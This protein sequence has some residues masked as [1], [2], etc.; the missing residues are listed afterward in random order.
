MVRLAPH[1][2]AVPRVESISFAARRPLALRHCG[3]R[4]LRHGTLLQCLLPESAALRRGPPL[5]PPLQ[6]KSISPASNASPPL[7]EQLLHSKSKPRSFVF[8]Y[9]RQHSF[10]SLHPLPPRSPPSSSLSSKHDNNSQS[11]TQARSTDCPRN[12]AY[13]YL[14]FITARRSCSFKPPRIYLQG[15]KYP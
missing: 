5:R 1:T 8:L 6:A 7:D 3:S 14:K 10:T 11:A 4:Q 9:I 2:D 13:T 12:R 15:S